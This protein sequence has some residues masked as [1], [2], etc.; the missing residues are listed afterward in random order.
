MFQRYPRE[1]KRPQCSDH[2]ERGYGNE[3]D[4]PARVEYRN[5]RDKH[6]NDERRHRIANADSPQVR[7]DADFSRSMTVG[8][9][10]VQPPVFEK[11][12]TRR[13]CDAV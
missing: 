10:I 4:S 11:T 5:D 3:K 6:P 13:N 2:C 9:S 1:E 12:F 8:E 7:L